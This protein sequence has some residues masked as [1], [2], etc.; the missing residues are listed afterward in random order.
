M[1]PVPG[2]FSG[3]SGHGAD[4]TRHS[5]ARSSGISVSRGAAFASD[6]SGAPAAPIEPV[7]SGAFLSGLSVMI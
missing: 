2:L 5:A 4:V 7:W 6:A 1:E 3:P